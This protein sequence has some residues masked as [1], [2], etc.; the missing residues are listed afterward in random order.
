MQIAILPS[1]FAMDLREAY[2]R[3]K[4]HDPL[5]GSAFYEHEASRTLSKQGRSFLL[6]QV[7]ASGSLTRYYFNNPPK[8]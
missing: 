1:L 7:Q 2:T 8:Y 4:E 3:A 6:P 5:F